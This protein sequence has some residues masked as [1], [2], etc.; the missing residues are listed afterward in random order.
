MIDGELAAFLEEG[1]AIHLG[2]RNAQLEPDGAR[3][4]AVRVDADATHIVAFVPEVAAQ[5]VLA[6]LEANGQAALVFARP[7]DERACQLKGTF[8]GARPATADDRALVDAQWSRWLARLATIGYPLVTFDN[9]TTWP[10]VAVRVRVNAIFN[11]T[12]GPGAGA[13]LA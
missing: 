1:I 7:P 6:N 4:V 10:C 13:P 11:Q 9:W 5:R 8:A 12:P 2:T 3:V